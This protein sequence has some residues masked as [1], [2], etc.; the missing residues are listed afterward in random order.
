MNEDAQSFWMPSISKTS[1]LE[2]AREEA[3]QGQRPLEEP[4]LQRML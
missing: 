2:R 4:P 3:K 1:R